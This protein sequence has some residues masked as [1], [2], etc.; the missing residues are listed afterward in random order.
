MSASTYAFIALSSVCCISLIMLIRFVQKYRSMCNKLVALD[1]EM[2]SLIGDYY[3][4]ALR[5]GMYI[6]YKKYAFYDYM[7]ANFGSRNYELPSWLPCLQWLNVLQEG[8]VSGRKKRVVLSNDGRTRLHRRFL[9]CQGGMRVN[10]GIQLN[11]KDVATD[12]NKDA[13][14]FILTEPIRINEQELEFL[15]GKVILV[16]YIESLEWDVPIRVKY[17]ESTPFY[18]TGAYVTPN[19]YPKCIRRYRPKYLFSYDKWIR[20]YH[21]KTPKKQIN[22][23]NEVY[24]LRQRLFEWGRG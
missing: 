12:I 24:G 14:E 18:L 17:M 20:N 1:Q 16:E 22:W 5:K 13:S 4:I 6:D 3:P 10:G 15:I 23:S 8:L 19:E 9:S 7:Y 21:K 2:C 11:F